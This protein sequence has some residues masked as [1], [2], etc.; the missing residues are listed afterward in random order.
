M[1]GGGDGATS[2]SVSGQPPPA[3]ATPPVPESA[4]SYRK[5]TPTNNQNS[6]AA[7]QPRTP[8]NQTAPDLSPQQPQ[9][10][11]H[12]VLAAARASTP[13]TLKVGTDERNQPILENVMLVLKV[14]VHTCNVP[15]ETRLGYS[16]AVFLR[17][18]GRPEQHI[19]EIGGW[20]VSKPCK[21][22]PSID[23]KYMVQELL[24]TP[25][26]KIEEHTSWNELALALRVVYTQAGRPRT[27]VNARVRPT[28]G[29]DGSELVFIQMLHI[30]WADE[31]GTV[32]QGNGFGRIALDMYYRILTSRLLA[33]WFAVKTPA[34]FLLVPG[35]PDSDAA[36]R[37]ESSLQP[38]E[39]VD[40][41]VFYYRVENTLR[42][43]YARWGYDVYVQNG[44]VRAAGYD[45][46]LTVMGRT[47]NSPV[48]S[49]PADRTRRVRHRM[50]QPVPQFS[51]P[52]DSPMRHRRLAPGTGGDDDNDD[53]T[54]PLGQVTLRMPA[55][56]TG[57][58]QISTP[59][60]QG[61]ASAAVGADDF[62]AFS[63]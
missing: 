1:R 35:L 60:N 54:R 45:T 46:M 12:R 57:P 9:F 63:S 30:M 11:T 36:L 6:Q 4:S 2:N 7:D 47:F 42:D 3:V 50:Y 24:R 25:L 29:D 20:R 44:R 19:G 48:P 23:P 52:A 26:D 53:N 56:G 8:L 18:D 10:R 21:A 14:Q 37:W 17:R 27:T 34:T 58:A 32:F 39:T 5:F 16:G 62:V 15:F 22:Q 55:R 40:S 43:M 28:L 31:D 33:A 13:C 59:K 61:Q 41:P 51:S 49:D 38:G